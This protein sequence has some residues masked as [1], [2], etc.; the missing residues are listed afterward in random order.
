[1][2]GLNNKDFMKQMKLNPGNSVIVKK[3]V[4]DPDFEDLDLG[5]WQGRV[6]IIDSSSN[7]DNTLIT[8]EWDS[9]TLKQIPSWYIEQSETEGYDWN[10]MVLFE[11]DVEKTKAR[12]KKGDANNVRKKLENEYYWL[13]LGEEGIRIGRILHG[14]D[15]DDIMECLLCW[16]E[17]LDEN[18]NFPVAA[19]VDETDDYG[20]LKEG[21]KVSIK[22]LPHLEDLRGIIAEIR[23]GRSKYAFPLCELEV[24]DK[25][26]PDYQLIDDYRVWFANR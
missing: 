12:D 17:Y 13:H 6:I 1:M 5:G 15:P 3:G 20:P 2:N 18:L 16:A 11:T 9:K 8:I 24:I 23:L 21:E 14:I 7:P 26:S 10:I 4:K 25:K 22:S 19:I